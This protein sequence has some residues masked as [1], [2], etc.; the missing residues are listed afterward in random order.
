MLTP[1]IIT[2]GQSWN[3]A[4]LNGGRTQAF[5]LLRSMT[6]SRSASVCL[7]VAASGKP[8]RRAASARSIALSMVCQ[9]VAARGFSPASAS[10]HDVSRSLMRVFAPGRSPLSAKAL[11]STTIARN[12]ERS[13]SFDDSAAAADART[14]KQ[15][16][17][18]TAR[19]RRSTGSRRRTRIK[20]RMGMVISLAG[21]RKSGMSG[22][23]FGGCDVPISAWSSS[24]FGH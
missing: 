9:S 17:G 7:H 13:P 14:V 6:P 10:S 22:R 18:S 3:Q 15:W 1:R 23:F 24:E 16:V 19:P 2:R 21:E 11:V 5:P 8:A 20:K 4:A 12:E